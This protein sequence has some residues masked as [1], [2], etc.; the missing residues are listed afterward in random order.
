MEPLIL[1]GEVSKGDYAYLYDRVMLKISGKQRY[2]TQA[3]CLDGK[4]RSTVGRCQ[5]R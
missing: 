2:G 1:S 3:M 4:R 5:G